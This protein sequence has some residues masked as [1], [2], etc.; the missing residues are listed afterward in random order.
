M[1]KRGDRDVGE[2]RHGEKSC[3]GGEERRV[4]ETVNV[5]GARD[6]ALNRRVEEGARKGGGEC[7]CVH[8]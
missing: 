4:L 6:G 1:E 5:W 3:H 8:R 2:E 7:Q